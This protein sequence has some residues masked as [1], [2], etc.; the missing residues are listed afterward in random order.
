MKTINFL[1]QAFG[2]LNTDDFYK[3]TFG[4]I[5]LKAIKWSCFLAVFELFLKEYLGLDLIVFFAFVL[6]IIAEYI[7]GIKAAR[8]Q[9]K[10]FESRK[11]GRMIFKICIYLFV[12][13]L[14]F[15]FSKAISV[16]EIAGLEINPF[17]WLYYTVFF[18]IVFQLFVSYLENLGTLGYKESKTI[19]GIILR[20]YN[21]KF[22]FD[23][24][25]RDTGIE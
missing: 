14:L 7:T 22:E 23:G 6:L 24:K 17:S 1:I 18:A 19:V 3:S 2:F 4:A 21:E 8:K 11:A 16:P 9:G 25:K 5:S 13:F 15:S 12:I 20:K 10:R